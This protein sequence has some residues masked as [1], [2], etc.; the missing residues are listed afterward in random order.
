[1]DTFANAWRVIRGY[2][3]RQYRKIPWRRRNFNSARPC[4]D[5]RDN[6]EKRSMTWSWP[7]PTDPTPATC[8]A[9]V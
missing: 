1:M 8:H 4:A 9:Q 5:C 3:K 6:N 7:S 2:S